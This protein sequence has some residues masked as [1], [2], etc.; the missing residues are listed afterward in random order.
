MRVPPFLFQAPSL[1][2]DGHDRT[3][4]AARHLLGHA[5]NNRLRTPPSLEKVSSRPQPRPM[6]PLLGAP[7]ENRD[8]EGTVSVA[9]DPSGRH[10]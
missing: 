6:L 8:G 3:W 10:A 4:S 5:P 1:L 9:S 7:K 2:L